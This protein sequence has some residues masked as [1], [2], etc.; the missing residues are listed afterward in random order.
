MASDAVKVLKYSVSRIEGLIRIS[1]ESFVDEVDVSVFK[2]LK[3]RGF[4]LIIGGFVLPRQ[5]SSAV[6]GLFADLSNAKA[7]A[8]KMY[9]R[10]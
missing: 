1:K 10:G 2:D 7:S 8:A 6:T 5:L 3:R 9:L 4:Y